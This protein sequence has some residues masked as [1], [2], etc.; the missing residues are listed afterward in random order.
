[1]GAKP[2]PGPI[3]GELLLDFHENVEVI[4]TTGINMFKD[5]CTVTCNGSLYLTDLRLIYIPDSIQPS[6]PGFLSIPHV[7][8]GECCS[9][10]ESLLAIRRMILQ[11][12]ISGIQDIKFQFL[13]DNITSLRI[14]CRN[15][16]MTEFFV[17]EA[18][19]N[20]IVLSSNEDT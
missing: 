13:K 8:K 20:L 10:E 4:M 11:Y 3:C 18:N 2:L 6:P 15:S 17:N 7:M 16:V 19:S 1:L 14:N 12:P 5:K 9:N